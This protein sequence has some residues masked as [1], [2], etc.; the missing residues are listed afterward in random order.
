MPPKHQDTKL[1]QKFQAI[2]AFGGQ[3]LVEVNFL[4]K[5]GQVVF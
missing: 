2:I 4:N 1:H 5:S 3:Q